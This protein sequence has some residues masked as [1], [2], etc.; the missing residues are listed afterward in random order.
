MVGLSNFVWYLVIFWFFLIFFSF[1]LLFP[2]TIYVS[3]F[4]SLVTFVKKCHSKFI[5]NPVSLLC[6]F[7]HTRSR[8]IEEFSANY[9]LSGDQSTLPNILFFSCDQLRLL[10]TNHKCSRN[11][12]KYIYKYSFFQRLSNTITFYYQ[13][14]I[15]TEI[16]ATYVYFPPRG[17]YNFTPFPE[18]L[19][20]QPNCNLFRNCVLAV[21]PISHC[22]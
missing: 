6:K 13:L 18:K 7:A 16:E 17:I 9:C 4:W 22:K 11:Y 5:Y 19:W 3:P 20:L 15:A 10:E 8:E 21:L 2:A 1:R 14:Q 12:S